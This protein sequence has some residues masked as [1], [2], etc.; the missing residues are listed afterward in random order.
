MY[1][2]L[3]IRNNLVVL[4]VHLIFFN[5]NSLRSFSNIF[6]LIFFIL[7]YLGIIQFREFQKTFPFTP[8]S[9]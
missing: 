4:K 6:L 5:F 7:I 3:Q 9:S 1:T 2:C 8:C